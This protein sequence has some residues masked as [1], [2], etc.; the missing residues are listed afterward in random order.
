MEAYANHMNEGL[1]METNEKLVLIWGSEDIL[2]SSIENFLSANEDWK[3]ISFSNPDDLDALILT[4]EAM[5]PDIVIII[6]QD[7]EYCLSDRL[8]Q[9]LQE[10]TEIK[11]V[12]ISLENNLMEIY[13]KQK[14]LVKNASDLFS[15]I[16]KEA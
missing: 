13:N 10:H 12:M 15:V 16:E 6:H 4:V 9:L 5:H 1:I 3:V 8:L 7:D 14:I 11:L 2:S